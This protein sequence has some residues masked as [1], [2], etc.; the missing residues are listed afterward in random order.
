MNYKSYPFLQKF[1]IP[2]RNAQLPLLFH[3]TGLRI[4]LFSDW[5]A[6]IVRLQTHKATYHTRQSQGPALLF[7]EREIYQSLPFSVQGLS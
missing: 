1:H 7:G 6:R 5:W 4:R 2:S 3:P